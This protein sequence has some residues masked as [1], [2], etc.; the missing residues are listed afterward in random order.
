M[1]LRLH[2]KYGVNPTIPVCFVCG[3]P[4]NEVVLLGAGYKEEAPMHLC[5]DKEPCEECKRLASK[6]VMLVEVQD[7]TDKENPYKTGK[8]IVVK[9]EAYKHIFNTEV[10]PK[11]IAFIEE[12]ALKKIMGDK[13]GTEIKETK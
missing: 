12:T 11:R 8:I 3:K 7:N 1:S 13:Y 4:K 2:S 10:P 5:I 6:G 9:E